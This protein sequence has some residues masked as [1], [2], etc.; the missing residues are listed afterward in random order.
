MNKLDLNKVKEMTNNKIGYDCFINEEHRRTKA[1]KRTVMTFSIIMFMCVS[2]VTVNALTDN[3]IIKLFTGKAMINGE[4][5]DVK[6]YLEVYYTGD[7]DPND[8]RV[9]INKISHNSLCVESEDAKLKVCLTDAKEVLK[10]E[11]NYDEKNKHPTDWTITY[12]DIN[13]QEQTDYV[14]LK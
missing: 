8:M 6:S 3:G 10:V 12:I 4:E 1:I 14:E 13:D 9:V 11:M 7:P 5:K 2:L